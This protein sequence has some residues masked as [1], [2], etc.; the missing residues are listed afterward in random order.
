MSECDVLFIGK[1]ETSVFEAFNSAMQRVFFHL[2]EASREERGA[3]RR[4]KRK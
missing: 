1:S 4:E 3:G 2:K